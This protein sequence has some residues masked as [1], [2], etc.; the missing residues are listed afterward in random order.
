[1]AAPTSEYNLGDIVK[2]GCDYGNNPG[3]NKT[4]VGET[5]PRGLTITRMFLKNILSTFDWPHLLRSGTFSAAANSTSCTIT[6]ADSN[7]YRAIDLV[8]ITSPAGEQTSPLEQAAYKDI[9]QKIKQDNSYTAPTTGTPQFFAMDPTNTTPTMLL[10]PIPQRA[11]S[12]TALYYCLPSVLSYTTSSFVDFPDSFALINAVAEVV[13]RWD[14]E[15]HEAVFR[16]VG[17]DLYGRVRA[18]M[19]DRGRS[20]ARS[21]RWGPSFRRKPSN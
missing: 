13:Q 21:L 4:P 15:P 2:I 18:S 1:M 19:G 9:L 5:E 8:T 3:L 10:W 12:G 20:N 17:Q 6:L 14:K 16:L 7:A 11:Y